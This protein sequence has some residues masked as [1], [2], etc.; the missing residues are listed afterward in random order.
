MRRRLNPA[1]R[2]PH[3]IASPGNLPATA[4]HTCIVPKPHSDWCQEP[5]HRPGPEG[6]GAPERQDFNLL[7]FGRREFLGGKGRKE[8]PLRMGN[9]DHDTRGTHFGQGGTQ[10][11]HQCLDFGRHDTE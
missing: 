8:G 10:K 11:L 6:H 3:G 4:A 2:R 1:S 9:V 7:H 5:D